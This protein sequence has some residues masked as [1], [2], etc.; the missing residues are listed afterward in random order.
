MLDFDEKRNFI[1]METNCKMTFKFPDSEQVYEGICLNLSG[2]GVLFKADQD[3]TLGRALESQ[4]IPENKI[5][6]PLDA[7]VEVIRN[8]P[9][10]DGRYKI[11]AVIKGIKGT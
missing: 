1:R 5:T 6:P 7:F 3:I 8:T 4:I 11:A 10:A 9:I 2:A